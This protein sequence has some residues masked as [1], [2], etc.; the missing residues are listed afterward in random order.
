MDTNEAPHVLVVE[1]D[2]DVRELCA[3][4]LAEAGYAVGEAADGAEGLSYLLERK[5]DLIVLD[6]R[7]PRVD[8]YEFLRRM[9]SLQVRPEPAVVVVSAVAN[10]RRLGE[11]GPLRLVAKPFAAEAL[12]NE[13]RSLLGPQHLDASG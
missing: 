8:G 3:Q 5:P 9:R 12:L 13:V 2:A 1:D 10:P 6:L 7:M 4:I 11:L